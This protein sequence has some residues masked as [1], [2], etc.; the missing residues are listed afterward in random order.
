LD[1]VSVLF[2]R[3][4]LCLKDEPVWSC[5]GTK[6]GKCKDRKFIMHHD[7]NMTN[8]LEKKERRKSH[9]LV[10]FPA[11]TS[12]YDRWSFGAA[13]AVT[14]G[15]VTAGAV[16]AGAVTAGAVTAGAVTAGAV[17]AA[18]SASAAASSKSLLREL[19][20]VGRLLGLL[21]GPQTRRGERH[22]SW[23]QQR[24]SSDRRQ[25]GLSAFLAGG[26]VLLRGA[27]GGP[28]V[29]PPPPLLAIPMVGGRGGRGGGRR[30][31]DSS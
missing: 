10:V 5:V 30:W 28:S 16:T 12:L 9:S 6:K 17:T 7:I 11:T 3:V 22:C 29:P 25:L 13:G 20:L 26:P 1:I 23:R 8:D 4:F 14:A 2:S 15:A 27:F 21:L 31:G 19:L 24:C 18:W